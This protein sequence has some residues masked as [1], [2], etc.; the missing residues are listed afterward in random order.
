MP[1]KTP[2]P[3][4]QKE[5]LRMQRNGR[6]TRRATALRIAL[7]DGAFCNADLQHRMQMSPHV[8]SALITD[9]E[10][11]GYLERLPKTGAMP[12]R[13]KISAAGIAALTAIGQAGP[14]LVPI[15][16][17]IRSRAKQPG[18][19]AESIQRGLSGRPGAQL[20]VPARA[21]IDASVTVHG[22]MAP[23]GEAVMRDGVRITVCPSPKHDDRYQVAPGAS[24]WG[25][26]FAAAGLGRD[27]TTGRGWGG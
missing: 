19:M 24:V 13:W 20:V 7:R 23:Q 22:S 11:A 1:A 16:E 15:T 27:I 5:G 4:P 8:A 9:L 2:K 6:L 12:N 3:A 10:S 21:A 18:R 26:G 17:V 14:E 25:A